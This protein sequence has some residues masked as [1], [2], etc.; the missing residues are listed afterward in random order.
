[1]GRTLVETLDPGIAG[2]GPKGAA[3]L[4]NRHGKIEDFPADVLGEQRELALLFKK[5]ATLRTDAPLFT[6]PD[7]L[8]WNGPT[9]AFAAFSAR[10]GDQRVLTRA[11]KALE[12]AGS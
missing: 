11:Q 1:M 7:A 9:Q 8:R 5:L 4:L 2:I 12:K 10:C 6:H 3:S